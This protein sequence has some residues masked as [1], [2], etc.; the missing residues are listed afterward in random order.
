M[1]ILPCVLIPK[2]CRLEEV[3]NLAETGVSDNDFASSTC[4]AFR[5]ECIHECLAYC[6]RLSS[7]E[8]ATNVQNTAIAIAYADLAKNKDENAR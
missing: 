8:D 5:L 7:V 4:H 6:Q 2:P 1:E 3:A